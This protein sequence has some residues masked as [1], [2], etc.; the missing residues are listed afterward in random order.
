MWK[1]KEG[2]YVY[3]PGGHGGSQDAPSDFYQ[4]VRDALVGIG[5]EEPSWSYKYNA[6]ANP[7]CFP[8]PL[9]KAQH[10]ILLEVLK[11]AYELA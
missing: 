7:I 1:R 6:G 11:E 4:K 9:E 10:S 2:V 3:I 5:L 8:I